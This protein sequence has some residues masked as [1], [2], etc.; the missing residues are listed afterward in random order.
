MKDIDKDVNWLTLET[1]FEE[2]Y[3]LLEDDS[4]K[5]Y[6]TPGHTPGHISVLVKLENSKSMFLTSD[7]CYTEENLNENI[8]PGLVWNEEQSIKSLNWI[9]KLQKENNLEIIVGHD[10]KAWDRFKKPPEY[11]S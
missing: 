10:P 5:I 8:L 2:A 9:R 1:K 3:D 7:S 6:S 4:I 11:Y